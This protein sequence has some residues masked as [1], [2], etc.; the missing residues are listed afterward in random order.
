M[1]RS[2]SQ[3]FVKYPINAYKIF[4][5][6]EYFQVKASDVN[7]LAPASPASDARSELVTVDVSGKHFEKVNVRKLKTF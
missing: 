5:H 3:I 4:V 2:E 1:I 7:G 6:G